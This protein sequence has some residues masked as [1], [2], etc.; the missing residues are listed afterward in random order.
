M[1]VWQAHKARVRH[2]AF[3]PDGSE[4]ATTAGSSK[5]VWRW[6]AATGELVGQLQGHTSYARAV[7]YSPDG[8]F[9]ASSQNAAHAIVWDRATWNV[10]AHLNTWWCTDSIA[11]R[12][13]S[14][15]LAAAAQSGAGEWAV[16]RFEGKKRGL[17]P[18][19]QFGTG[20]IQNVA[21]SPCD[22]YFA[23]T[24]YSEL[25]LYNLGAHRKI[26]TFTDPLASADAVAL[27]FS[28]DGDTL[29]V[30]FGQRIHLLQ[31]PHGG[32]TAV[33]KGHTNYI[34]AVGFLPDGRTLVSAAA[35][36][37]VRVWDTATAT[38]TRSFDWGI[39]KVCAAAI[40]PDGMLC[41]AAGANG[42]VVVW[43]VDG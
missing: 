36:G 25:T 13:D 29:A 37:T 10:V 7:A 4:L 33:L 20:F 15:A 35:D 16:E 19:H 2:M 43:D 31:L 11:F 28:P 30:V 26:H 38:E 24:C 23:L 34:H 41:A 22:R 21:Y 17:G 18:S 12:P 27:A 3:S 40:S 5:F 14:S 42:K 32:E 39:G 1:R 6:R 9:L 8:H